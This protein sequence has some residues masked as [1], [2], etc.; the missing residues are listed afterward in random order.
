LESFVVFLRSIW[1]YSDMV[2]SGFGFEISDTAADSQSSPSAA[3]TDGFGADFLACMN[4]SWDKFE[5]DK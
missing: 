2:I 1:F 4:M 3:A 5:T